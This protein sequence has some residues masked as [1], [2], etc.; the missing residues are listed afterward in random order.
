[1]AGFSF[2]DDDLDKLQRMF[3]SGTKKKHTN[4]INHSSEYAMTLSEIGAVLGVS[5]E[6]VRQII[7]SALAKIKK[8][9]RYNDLY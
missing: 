4:I 3:S 8:R 7:N 1:M 9:Y 2:Q 6:R 5:R